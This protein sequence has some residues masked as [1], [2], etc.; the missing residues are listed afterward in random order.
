MVVCIEVQQ[1]RCHS[2]V[3]SGLGPRF[4]GLSQYFRESMRL[5]QGHNTTLQRGSNKGPLDDLEKGADQLRSYCEAHL[6]LC[7]RQCRLLVFS[8][9]CSYF[10]PLTRENMKE[11]IEQNYTNVSF[12]KTRIK[13]MK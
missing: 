1:P 2:S 13:C 4:L 3:M 12:Q 9:G 8:C 7:F 10:M 5:A 6:R 11:F